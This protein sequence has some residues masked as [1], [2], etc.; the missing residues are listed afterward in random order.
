MPLLFLPGERKSFW[1]S[2]PRRD[3]RSQAHRFPCRP[4]APVPETAQRRPLRAYILLIGAPFWTVDAVTI[5]PPRSSKTFDLVCLTVRLPADT[6]FSLDLEVRRTLLK[7]RFEI[8]VS[9]GN[10]GQP[11]YYDSYS[12]PLLSL[13]V[14]TKAWK[15]SGLFLKKKPPCTM[16][17]WQQVKKPQKAPFATIRMGRLSEPGSLRNANIRSGGNLTGFT[18]R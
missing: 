4:A 5:S 3:S 11:Q 10:R 13:Q 16:P 17:Q 2:T 7:T 12:I 14:N 6:L 8:A 9:P 18:A 1:I 15:L